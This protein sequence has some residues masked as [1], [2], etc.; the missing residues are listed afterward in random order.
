MF[1]SP[2][3]KTKLHNMMSPRNYGHTWVTDETK[4]RGNIVSKDK[5]YVIR[6]KRFSKSSLFKIISHNKRIFHCSFK[7]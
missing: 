4:N 3:R 2:R 7:V 5:M 6:T 1:G